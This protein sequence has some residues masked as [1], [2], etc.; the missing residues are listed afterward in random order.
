[1][2]KSSF[3]SPLGSPPFLSTGHFGVGDPEHGL[4]SE[5]EESMSSDRPKDPEGCGLRSKGSDG[6]QQSGGP[7]EGTK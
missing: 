4:F 7:K 2:E 5:R 6:G 3:L 1:M